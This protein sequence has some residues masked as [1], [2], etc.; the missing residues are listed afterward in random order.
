ME[1][2]LTRL[3]TR[4][5][6]ADPANLLR[7]GFVMVRGPDGRPLRKVAGALAGEMLQVRLADG[8]IDCE[9]KKVVYEEKQ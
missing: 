8:R 7:K 3:E 6:A 4:L 2:C 5:D 1:A 9:I